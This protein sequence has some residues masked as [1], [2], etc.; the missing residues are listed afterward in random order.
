MTLMQT[1]KAST[2]LRRKPNAKAPLETELL[3]GELFDVVGTHEGWAHGF[4]QIDGY[5]GWVKIDDLEEHLFVPTHRVAAAHALV[6]ENASFK[7]GRRMVLHMNSLVRVTEAPHGRLE[8]AEGTLVHVRRGG[9]LYEEQLRP[10]DQFACDYVEE[11]LKF[12]GT[13]YEWGAR[14]STFDCSALVQAALLATGVVVPRDCIPQSTCVG[15]PVE[16]ASWKPWRGDLVFWTKDKGRHVAIMVDSLHCVHAT[17]LP[18]HRGV[19]V[20]PL[21]EVIRAQR[22]SENGEPSMVRR[23]EE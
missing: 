3:F 18:P 15:L 13:P 8:T 4:A 23:F 11:A 6:Y 12:V 10:I 22:E 21:R 1:I 9:W 7:Q 17:I 14:T 16:L 5:K 19:V 2:E 20:Q